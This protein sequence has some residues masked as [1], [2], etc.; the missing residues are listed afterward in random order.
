VRVERHI[1]FW[2]GAGIVL[3]ALVAMLSAVLL[4]FVAGMVIAYFLNPLVDW[5]ER[6]GFGRA[7]AVILI[8]AGALLAV[9]A[10]VVLLAPVVIG[11]IRLLIEA[12]PS[13]LARLQAAM[14]TW[15][16]QRRG[17][18]YPELAPAIE[19]AMTAVGQMGTTAVAEVAK[20]I[21]NQGLALVNLMSLLLIT[22]VVVVYL[23]VDWHSM[24]ARVDGWLPREQAPTLRR[25]AGEI[26]DVVAAFVRG[27]GTIC[28]ILG[29]LYATALGAL[30]LPYGV[31]IGLFTGLAG[32]VPFVGWALGLLI[33]VGVAIAQA[34]PE[35][36]LPVQVGAI[37]LAGMAIDSAFLGP[38]LVGRR[39]GLHPVWLIFALVVFSYLF[40][41]L[42]V[43][44]AVPVAAA[45]GVL[46]RFGLES[47][48]ASP[49]YNGHAAQDS[50]APPFGD[51]SGPRA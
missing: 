29:A 44:V 49:I 8:L 37:F 34:W 4:P 14:T 27:Q 46:V 28:L 33:A 10:V 23:L 20:A 50:K 42:G 36:G 48:L 13:D 41:F 5:L 12:V 43:L 45:I 38:R 26:D 30:G 11:Q 31:L 39:V 19:R 32:F 35:I 24:L 47:Y 9:V 21:W 22:P 1:L 2:L 25:L 17:G 7:L 18:R 3:L 51:Q 6:L 40:G 15:L 16:V